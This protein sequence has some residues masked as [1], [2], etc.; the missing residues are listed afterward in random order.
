MFV[1]DTCCMPLV[2]PILEW[3]WTWAKKNI[4]KNIIMVEVIKKE[5]EDKIHI[6]NLFLNGYVS[7]EKIL[8]KKGD[9]LFERTKSNSLHIDFHET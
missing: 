4:N 3:C 5:K 7:L 9:I 2:M 1:I 8:F 6:L